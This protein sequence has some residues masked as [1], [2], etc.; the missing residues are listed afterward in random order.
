VTR[1]DPPAA[2]LETVLYAPDLD[3]VEAFYRDVMGL[4]I[5]AKADGRH[6][7]YRLGHPMLLIFNPAVT[8]QPPARD[9]RI[10]VPPHGSRG[11][12]HVCFAAGADEIER[13]K[14]HLT[15]RGVAI[16]ADVEWPRGGRSIYFRDPAGNSI[17]IAEPRIWD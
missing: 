11:P 2:I 15:E 8:E 5:Y 12:G 10:P 17:E 13:W 1:P 7:F 14:M 9:A 16:E 3:A 6:L 4:S